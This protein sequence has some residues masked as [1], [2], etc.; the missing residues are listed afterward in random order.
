M[1]GG[2]EQHIICD[3]QN[4]T[5]K[6]NHQWPACQGNFYIMCTGFVCS[7]CW[8]FF[9]VLFC[10][11][12][13]AA[14]HSC[15]ISVSLTTLKM[16]EALWLIP[17]QPHKVTI[18]CNASLIFS[19]VWFSVDPTIRVTSNNAPILKFDNNP[20]LTRSARSRGKMNDCSE[21]LTVLSSSTD[22][23]NKVWLRYRSVKLMT[24]LQWH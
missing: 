17:K 5:Y 22:S 9:F 13:S 18:I 10:S 23:Q 12:L 7:F 19:E 16:V 20:K 6:W 11:P 15:A 1:S 4:I 21:I 3:N 24:K 14:R 2:W 8:D